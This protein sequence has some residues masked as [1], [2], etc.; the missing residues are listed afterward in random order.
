MG[1]TQKETHQFCQRNS[2]HPITVILG[3]GPL[4]QGRGLQKFCELKW[5]C[6]PPAA[7]LLLV[8]EVDMG[9]EG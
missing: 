4:F 2:E 1:P 3:S 5:Y 7:V 6:L 9:E 8:Q